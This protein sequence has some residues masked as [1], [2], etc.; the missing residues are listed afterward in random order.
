MKIL[1]ENGANL[2]SRSLVTSMSLYKACKS[3]VPEI[4]ETLIKNGADVNA[5]Y[6]D[7]F[8][9]PHYGHYDLTPLHTTICYATSTKIVDLLVQYGADVEKQSEGGQTALLMALFEDQKDTES[10]DI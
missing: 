9:N 4:V 1:V 3:D 10:H 6:G 8:G 2:G 7:Y 5:S